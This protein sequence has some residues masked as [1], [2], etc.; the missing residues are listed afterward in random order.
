MFSRAGRT[1]TQIGFF[2][3]FGTNLEVVSKGLKPAMLCA[4]LDQPHHR[5]FFV[6]P[7]RIEEDQPSRNRRKGKK[8]LARDW[9][10]Q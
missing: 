10:D 7:A 3:S 5:V 8:E 4:T 9:K 1:R 6:L 2:H